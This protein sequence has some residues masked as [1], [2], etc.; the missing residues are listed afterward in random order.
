MIFPWVR[1]EQR[2]KIGEVVGGGWFVVYRHRESGRI[3]IL[4]NPPIEY[5][6]ES[7]AMQVATELAEK[8]PDAIV[9]VLCVH[10]QF[11]TSKAEGES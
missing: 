2:A 7:D 8:F 4:A 5:A 1:E 11:N 9:T 3:A 6:S 10:T